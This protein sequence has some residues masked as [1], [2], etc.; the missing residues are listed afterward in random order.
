M[1]RKSRIQILFI[2]IILSFL[3]SCKERPKNPVAEYGDGMINSYK[4]GQRAGEMA[5]LDAVRKTIQ[6][7]HAANDRYPQGL[8]EVKDMLGSNIDLSRYD[9][10]PQT[11]EVALKDN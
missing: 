1:R 4:K 3:I 7:Y 2:V 9:Y 10:N 6:T 5:N 8:D 11:G